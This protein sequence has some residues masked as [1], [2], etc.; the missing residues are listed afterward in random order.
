MMQLHNILVFGRRGILYNLHEPRVIEVDI[1]Y[2]GML[3]TNA[4]I[5]IANAVD[6]YLL[7]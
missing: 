1:R 6:A 3:F 5:T 7:E 2:A 4:S